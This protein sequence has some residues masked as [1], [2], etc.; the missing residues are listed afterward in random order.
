MFT[1]LRR[2]LVS[3][4]MVPFVCLCLLATACGADEAADAVGATP[5]DPPS[6]TPADDAGDDGTG[7]DAETGDDADAEDPVGAVPVEDALDDPLDRPVELPNDVII[8]APGLVIEEVDGV[9]QVTETA[10]GEIEVPEWLEALLFS[11][12]LV[13]RIGTDYGRDLT[14]LDAHLHDDV[15]YWYVVIE[16]DTI[17]E[18]D[19]PELSLDVPRQW[20]MA[21]GGNSV[22]VLDPISG[23]VYAGMACPGISLPVNVD[24]R[25]SDFEGGCG[26]GFALDGSIPVDF[27]LADTIHPDFD[28]LHPQLVVD[29][30]FPVGPVNVAGSVFVDFDPVGLKAIATGQFGMG[31]PG[32]LGVVPISVPIGNGTLGIDHRLDGVAIVE[33]T[34]LNGYLGDDIIA[35]GAFAK[36]ADFLA[37][38]GDVD[39]DG[40]LH[41]RL[42]PAA[43]AVWEPDSYLDV[44]G[45]GAWNPHRLMPGGIDH[46][47]LTGSFAGRIDVDGIRGTG[48]VTATPF[49]AVALA[50]EGNVAFE[51]LYEDLGNSFLQIDGTLEVGGVDL[52]EGEL[53]IDSDGVEVTGKLGVGGTFVAVSG[54]IGPAGIQLTGEAGATIDLTDL[55]ALAAKIAGERGEDETIDRLEAEIDELAPH[56]AI[57]KLL[58]DVADAYDGIRTREELIEDQ[59]DKLEDLADIWDSYTAL[60]KIGKS[61]S[62]GLKVA[63]ANTAIAGLKLDIGRLRLVIAGAD[64]LVALYKQFVPDARAVD[65]ERFEA[66]KELLRQLKWERFWSDVRAVIAGVVRGAGTLLEAF[67]L[68][69][70]IEGRVKLSI[71]TEGLDADVI[72]SVCGDDWCVGID[73]SSFDPDSGRTCIGIGDSTSCGTV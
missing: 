1:T 5:A 58:D 38:Q 33:K 36:A 73:T 26:I 53:R 23:Y 6:S 32:K 22:F 27:R 35:E 45:E 9:P 62:H 46:D 15:L 67:G 60:E 65:V 41:R 28:A 18:I 66:L 55:D 72:A 29:G 54:R 57:Q 61:V 16:Q 48:T 59:R 64:G 37:L 24:L 17:L 10:T 71:G 47:T 63:A 21:G 31:L 11:R 13:G 2:R 42:D 4:L 34:W 70:R 43:L 52:A 7:E 51:M 20:D 8:D 44:E 56:A 14:D 68:D 25:I 12:G 50:A 49:A 40:F 69:L 30:E 39:I 19:L 3:I